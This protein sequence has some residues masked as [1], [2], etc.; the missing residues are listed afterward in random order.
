ML[1]NFISPNHRTSP[2]SFAAGWSLKHKLF[3]Y[4][5]LLALLLLSA[6]MAGLFLLGH[7]NSTEKNTFQ[8]LDLQLEL[9]EKIST[10]ISSRSLQPV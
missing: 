5:L 8:A 9:F 3:G 4:M 6:V 1:N 7:M 10:I 2:R